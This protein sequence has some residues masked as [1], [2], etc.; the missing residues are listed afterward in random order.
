MAGFTYN[1]IHCSD[2]GLEYIPTRDEQWFS[3]PEYDV[4]DADVDWRHG[5]YY[6]DSK[7]KVRTFTLKCFFEEI[8]VATRQ[9]IKEWVRR[10][11]GGVLIFDEMPFVYW[12][13]RPGKIPVGNWCLDN[14]EKHSGTV[15][16]TFNAYDPFGYLTR[17]S[18][19]M[20]PSPDHAED[21]CNMIDTADMPAAPTTSSTYFDIYNPGTE[22]CGMS[23]ELA[24]TAGKPFRFFNEL[25]K[26]SCA[27][28]SLPTNNLHVAIDGDSGF[29]SVFMAGS[30]E[31]ESG[32][33][34]HD[35][36]VLRLSPNYG[37]SDLSFTYHGMSGT[38]YAID[39]EGFTATRAL[40][41]AKVKIDGIGA[42][43]TVESVVHSTEP[44]IDRIYC[45][46]EE[47][48]TV[49][50]EGTLSLYTLNHI[51]IEEKVGGAWVSPSNLTLTYINVNYRP[52]AM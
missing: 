48:I 30:D 23:I 44:G 2:F 36:G 8:T 16:I 37:R 47:A 27:F 25:N 14:N 15:T 43:L 3:D 39:L 42:V 20:T 1:G 52:K 10:D 40:K 11:S 32:F 28:E 26:T 49:P 5:G 4:Y 17:K 33:M 51:V 19:T 22:D 29:V 18:N 7:A 13:V 34:Y 35:K 21:Y 6:F 46:A 38:T 41:G 31:S 24:G 45:S 50:A 12:N 9:A